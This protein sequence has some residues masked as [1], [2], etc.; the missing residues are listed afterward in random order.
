[1]GN[2]DATEVETEG[3]YQR[4]RAA[5]SSL[6]L[7]G[8]VEARERLAA[9]VFELLGL[10]GRGGGHRKGEVLGSCSPSAMPQIFPDNGGDGHGF[11]GQV[12]SK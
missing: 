9:S 5:S 6:F 8:S 12:D 4:D 1:M 7:R 2:R 11:G 3:P 10:A